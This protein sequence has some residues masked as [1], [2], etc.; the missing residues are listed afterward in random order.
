MD[1]F[2]LGLM[3]KRIVEELVGL[4]EKKEGYLTYATDWDNVVKKKQM[5]AVLWLGKY[6][7]KAR[8]KFPDWWVHKGEENSLQ[9]ATGKQKPQN[10][11]PARPLTNENG[12]GFF[13][14]LSNPPIWS[15]KLPVHNLVTLLG[16]ENVD[17]LRMQ[18]PGITNNELVVLKDRKDTLKVQLMLWKLQG[19]LAKPEDVEES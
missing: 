18:T 15:K 11:T 16:Q 10:G 13:A 2:V 4:V 7:K 9:N 19:F 3:R 14:M 6:T 12:P 8:T 1:S 5:A 17:S